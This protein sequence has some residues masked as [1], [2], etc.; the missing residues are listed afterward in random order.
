MFYT[1]LN[2]VEH[3]I[4]VIYIIFSCS[5]KDL[6]DILNVSENATDEE[7]EKAYKSMARLVHPGKNCNATDYR[8]NFVNFWNY[9]LDKNRAPGATGAFKA[10]G[11]A[12]EVLKDPIKRKAYDSIDEN[13]LSWLKN[14]SYNMKMHYYCL[15]AYGLIPSI[16]CF[17]II[18]DHAGHGHTGI[19][20][21]VCIKCHFGAER[22]RV[23]RFGK[24]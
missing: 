10:I 4:P 9:N 17:G 15:Y 11:K 13:P 6:Y 24:S 21:M 12:H 1:F 3:I 23:E 19:I 14:V 8:L 2:C 16:D 22:K 5:N 18:L 7:I 20:V